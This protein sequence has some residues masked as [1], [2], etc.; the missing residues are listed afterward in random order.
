MLDADVTKVHQH[1]TKESF[2]M[3]ASR[4]H[5]QTQ[6]HNANPIK[7]ADYE[8]FFVA[9]LLS[10]NPHN[11]NKN[12]TISAQKKGTCDETI[13]RYLR[14]VCD[15]QTLQKSRSTIEKSEY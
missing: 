7:M 9:K 8:I 10:S 1:R 5:T 4:E 2:E 11:K 6:T 12:N 14:E 13:R 3:D 15:R